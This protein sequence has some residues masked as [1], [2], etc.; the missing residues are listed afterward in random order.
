MKQL[1]LEKL[2]RNLG[3]LLPVYQEQMLNALNGNAVRKLLVTAESVSESPKLFQSDLSNE[4]FHTLLLILSKRIEDAEANVKEVLAICSDRTSV[5]NLFYSFQICL[6][7]E[8]LTGAERVYHDLSE[9]QEELNR[10]DSSG[11]LAAQE[12]KADIA[13]ALYHIGP[14]Y[15]PKAIDLYESARAG[16]QDV[17]GYDE[18]KQEFYTFW[19]GRILHLFTRMLNQGN[20]AKYAAGRDWTADFIFKEKICVLTRDVLN[21]ECYR[22]V[23]A[24]QAYIELMEAYHRSVFNGLTSPEAAI[25]LAIG[26]SC[27]DDQYC[28]EKAIELAPNDGSVLEKVGKYMRSRSK[29]ADDFQ[30]A[31][32]LLEHCIELFPTRH[33]SL[34]QLYLAYRSLWIMKNN[35]DEAKI[36]NNQ[37]RSGDQGKP[38]NRK[39]QHSRRGDS[40]GGRGRGRGRGRG[41][42]GN[43]VD[44]LTT[45]LAGMSVAIPSAAS[46][47]PRRGGTPGQ[48][49]PHFLRPDYFDVLRTSNSG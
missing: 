13:Y 4:N 49:P 15:Y 14:S 16:L 34:H 27:I 8:D 42:S 38:A 41:G 20:V 31:I 33:V 17:E 12:L 29:S 36:Y 45:Q 40:R 19:S 48:V 46:F 3:I 9:C 25:Q 7:K 18:T 22:S 37:L 2:T 44:R 10:G 47:P 28:I 21:A 23:Y 43:D 35:F 1:K 26:R 11:I 5:A 39:P 24:A 30:E 6:K 32:R